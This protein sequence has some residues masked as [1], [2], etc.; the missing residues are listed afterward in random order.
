MVLR[1]RS[2]DRQQVTCGLTS[3]GDLTG[4]DLVASARR[5]RDQDIQPHLLGSLLEASGVSCPIVSG[6][7]GR[8][9]VPPH[10]S[11]PL[12]LQQVSSSQTELPTRRLF[13]LDW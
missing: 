6:D 13:R 5:Q 8:N 9:R 1:Q 12:R 10:E 11:T 2:P 3:P 7:R 4:I